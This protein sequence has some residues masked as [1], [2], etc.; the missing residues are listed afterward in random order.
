[1]IDPGTALAAAAAAALL[2]AVLLWPDRGVVW[3]VSRS[4]RAGDRVAIEDALKHLYDGEAR[5]VPA[6]LHSLAGALGVSGDRAA[7]FVERL[8]RL[9]LVERADAGTYRLTPQGRSDA[10][11]VVRI[12]RLWERYL[13][14]E[15]G[16]DPAEWHREAERREH[17]TTDA[18]ADALAARL[19]HPRFDPHG[20]PIPTAGGEIPPPPGVPLTELPV[21]RVAEIV[22]VED[23]PSAVYAQLLAEGLHPGMLLRVSESDRRRVRFEADAEEHVLAPVVAANL[24]VSPLAEDAPMP[25]P[26]ERLS[27]LDPGESA[28][29]VALSPACRGLERRRLLDLGIV[30]GTLV[31]AE[32]RSAGGGPTA[33]RIRGA[34]IALRRE[35]AD[36]VQVERGSEEAGA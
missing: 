18:Q 28:R 12:H 34:L 21:G 31:A 17:R 14:E 2:A 7:S 9:D 5:D 22:H 23:E 24:S 3:R 19:G 4:F 29:V 25:G 6:T 11:R 1:M 8:E 35:Q 26:F 16:L 36:L 13:S 32:L 30:P 20:D 27:G 33:Y 10:L 15:T